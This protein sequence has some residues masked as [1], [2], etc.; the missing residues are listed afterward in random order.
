MGEL[1]HERRYAAAPATSGCTSIFGKTGQ[2]TTLWLN[3]Q[4]QNSGRMLTH[5]AGVRPGPAA[6]R[7]DAISLRARP[8]AKPRDPSGPH[9]FASTV[10]LFTALIPRHW[11]RNSTADLEEPCL[12]PVLGL[13]FCRMMPGYRLPVVLGRN[14]A[15]VHIVN[16]KKA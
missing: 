12:L 7:M 4:T 2:G 3:L 1:G 10:D 14:T 9:D 11:L 13:G 8:S 15:V 6:P 5:W 16:V